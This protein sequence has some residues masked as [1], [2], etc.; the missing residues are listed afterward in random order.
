M[1]MGIR[2]ESGRDGTGSP[3]LF[4]GQVVLGGRVGTGWA[5]FGVD[6]ACQGL[7]KDLIH[8]ID[9]DELDAAKD[10]GRNFAGITLVFQGNQNGIDSGT[11][12]SNDL[13]FQAADR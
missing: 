7:G 13:F 4:S 1:L 11:V 10:R 8:L 2:R 12:G 9:I 6:G 5:R 3:D